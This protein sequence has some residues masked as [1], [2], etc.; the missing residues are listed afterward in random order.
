M[1]LTDRRR[2]RILVDRLRL[3]SMQRVKSANEEL[4]QLICD[5]FYRPQEA[6]NNLRR[7]PVGCRG[8]RRRP[9]HDHLAASATNV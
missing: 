1:R 4:M 7:V 6:Y 9:V 5:V 2:D 3:H 8:C